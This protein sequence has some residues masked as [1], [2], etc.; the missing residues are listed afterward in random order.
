MHQKKI[1][2][3]VR[4]IRFHQWSRKAYAAFASL[5]RHVTMGCV[6]K[7][8]TEVSLS[9][10]AMCA[11]VFVNRIGADNGAVTDLREAETDSG[12]EEI[13]LWANKMSVSV[14]DAECADGNDGV[15]KRNK[16]TLTHRASVFVEKRHSNTEFRSLCVA[17][18]SFFVFN[19]W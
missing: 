4:S 16:I 6:R 13:L 7:G 1:S 19:L 9:K 2:Y 10:G 15:Y 18:P 12:V 11:Q 8:I 5:K 14:A 17:V 3:T